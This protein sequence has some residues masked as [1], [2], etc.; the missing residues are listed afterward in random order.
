MKSLITVFL[1]LVSTSLLAE[2]LK[3]SWDTA[4]QRTDNT[5]YLPADRGGSKVKYWLAGKSP[6]IVDTKSPTAE[7]ITIDVPPG[8]YQIRVNHYDS[9]G[10]NGAFSQPITKTVRASVPK[11]M[12]PPNLPSNVR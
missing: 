9:T 6:K 2:P 11:P 7:T 8:T 5:P 4:T 1:L 3:V 12:A 10:Q